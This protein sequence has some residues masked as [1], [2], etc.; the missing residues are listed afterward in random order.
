MS[1]LCR[2]GKLRSNSVKDNHKILP[3]FSVCRTC[4]PERDSIA[5]SLRQPCRCSK[6]LSTLQSPRLWSKTVHWNRRVARTLSDDGHVI[7]DNPRWRLN[8]CG[9][10]H[11]F[12]SRNSSPD[13]TDRKMSIVIASIWLVSQVSTAQLKDYVTI[14]PALLK[15]RLLHVE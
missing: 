11:R 5:K 8:S 14:T 10:L 15:R 7:L 4:P 9:T 13:F 12:T 1:L 3:L 2:T 6:T